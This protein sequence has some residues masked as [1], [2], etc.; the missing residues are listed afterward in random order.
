M[1]NLLSYS[2]DNLLSLFILKATQH[3]SKKLNKIQIN[4]KTCHAYGLEYLMLLRWEHSLNLSTDSMESLLE[5][6]FT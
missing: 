2:I 4:G 1:D 5:S 3:C 6:Q